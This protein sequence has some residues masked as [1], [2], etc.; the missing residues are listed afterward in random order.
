[1]KR[2]LVAALGLLAL[3]VVSGAMPSAALPLLRRTP[4][5]STLEVRGAG[6]R[7]LRLV[8]ADNHLERVRG[9]A[10]RRL[11]RADGLLLVYDPPRLVQLSFA[12]T[13][14]ALDVAFI[15]DE[16][17]VLATYRGVEPS[18]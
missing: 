12:R 18:F 9:L 14:R 6:D 16:G 1:M 11:V 17:T 15:D 10:G 7:H 5:L 8:V 4:E 3:G 13:C 2:S